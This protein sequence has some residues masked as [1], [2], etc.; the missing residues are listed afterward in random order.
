MSKLRDDV[1]RIHVLEVAGNA[2][3]GG[4]EKYV[5]SLIERL[6]ARDFRVTCV[7]PFES[8]FTERLRQLDTEVFVT[9]MDDDPHWNSIELVTALVRH[10][11]VDIIHAHLPKAHVL[12]GIAG[13]LA[14]VPVVA[15]VHQGGMSGHELAIAN[16][17]GSHLTAVCRQAYYDALTLGMLPDRIS[18]IYNGVDTQR[19]APGGDGSAFRASLGVPEGAP[20]V[21]FVGRCEWLKGPDQFIR[22]AESVSQVLPEA[23]FAVVGEGPMDAELRTLVAKMGL[24]GRM[25]LT[26]VRTDTANIYPAFSVL[27]QTSRSEGLPLVLLE[28]MACGLPVIAMGVGGI[29]EVVQAGISGLLAAPGD[30]LGVGRGIIR[31]LSNPELAAELGRAARRRVEESFNLD[32]TVTQMADLFHHLVR[33]RRQ[34]ASTAREEVARKNHQGK[35]AIV[36]GVR[37]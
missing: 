4:M 24:Q 28:A 37:E 22:A 5:C 10:L 17:T 29:V 15:T 1:N 32:D 21:G 3:V 34:P 14:G 18:L 6:P 23:H 36:A 9:P 12:A 25:H 7:A 33:A 19:F 35:Q 31:L 16:T 26:G 20:L 30:W 2:I 13:H 27:A 8:S 11:K